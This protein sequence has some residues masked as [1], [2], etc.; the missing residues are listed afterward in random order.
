MRHI[1]L[2]RFHRPS[3]ER[4]I[5]SKR[6]RQS[7]RSR[8][9]RSPTSSEFDVNKLSVFRCRLES[10]SNGV[11]LRVLIVRD[12]KIWCVR[13][14]SFASSVCMFSTLETSR[15]NHVVIPETFAVCAI[16]AVP[17]TSP[18][19]DLSPPVND[20]A[21]PLSTTSTAKTKPPKVVAAH[22]LER[23]HATPRPRAD[24]DSVVV[25]TMAVV[26][27][28]P[29]GATLHSRFQFFIFVS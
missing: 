7:R 1:L 12:R 18:R 4:N 16:R 26:R 15:R 25:A 24:I 10:F 6:S 28:S 14:L 3:F 9:P 13:F 29:Q 2:T 11:P 22:H 23:R 20:T 8:D 27:A 19:L 17:L 21:R 5:G